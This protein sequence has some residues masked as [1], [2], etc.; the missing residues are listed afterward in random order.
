VAKHSSG[1]FLQKVGPSVLAFGLSPMGRSMCKETQDNGNSK[2]M[3]LMLLEKRGH[4]YLCARKQPWLRLYC[5]PL[6]RPLLPLAWCDRFD[7]NLSAQQVSHNLTNSLAS[8]SGRL[9][10][11]ETTALDR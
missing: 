11:F 7:Q 2:G 4:R 1:E 10:I 8:Q 6:P 9:V 3:R 5:L